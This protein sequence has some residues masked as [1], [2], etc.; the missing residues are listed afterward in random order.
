VFLLEGLSQTVVNYYRCDECC[1]IW[2]QP[3]EKPRDERLKAVG[4]QTTKA[5]EV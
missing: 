5:L 3:K 1:H 4:P 2:T